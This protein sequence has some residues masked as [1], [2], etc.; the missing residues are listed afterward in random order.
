MIHLYGST[1][2]DTAKLYARQVARKLFQC[3]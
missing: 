2:D 1:K 3:L